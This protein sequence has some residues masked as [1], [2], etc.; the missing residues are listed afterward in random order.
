MISRVPTL[1]RSV[2]KLVICTH[3]S[4]HYLTLV[5]QSVASSNSS[6]SGDGGGSSSNS[7]NS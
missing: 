5:N 7:A 6:S 4:V 2:A 1:P 3:K